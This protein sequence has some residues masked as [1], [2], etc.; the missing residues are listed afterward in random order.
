LLSIVSSVVPQRS[1][2]ASNDTAGRPDSARYRSSRGI[3]EAIAI[4]FAREGGAAH[5]R[6]EIAADAT[7]AEGGQATVSGNLLATFAGRRAVLI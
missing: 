3:G 1:R 6:D 5:G 7:N 2:G 4:Q